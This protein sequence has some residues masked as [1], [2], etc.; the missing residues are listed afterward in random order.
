MANTG[1]S[2]Q[3]CIQNGYTDIKVVIYRKYFDNVRNFSDIQIEGQSLPLSCYI[4]NV[5]DCGGSEKYF[6]SIIK[7]SVFSKKEHEP[8]TITL[9]FKCFGTD[10]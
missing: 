5:Y 6:H 8:D 7:Q 2:V 3:H 9:Y 1:L 4:D 10:E